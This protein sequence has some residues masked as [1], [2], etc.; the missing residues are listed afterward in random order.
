LRYPPTHTH[1]PPLLCV[2]CMNWS[3]RRSDQGDAR[4]FHGTPPPGVLAN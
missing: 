4:V 3:E 2:T 1:P